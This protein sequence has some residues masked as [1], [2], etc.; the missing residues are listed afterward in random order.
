M[1]PPE[2]SRIGNFVVKFVHQVSFIAQVDAS[3]LAENGIRALNACADQVQ[4]MDVPLDILVCN[5]G[6]FFRG[7]ESRC[8]ASR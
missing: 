5:A 1:S 6:V 4:A 7:H 2:Y 3:N 8:A